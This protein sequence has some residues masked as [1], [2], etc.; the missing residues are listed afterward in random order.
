MLAG[1]VGR[2]EEALGS[3]A[4]EYISTGIGDNKIVEFDYASMGLS[5]EEAPAMGLVSKIQEMDEKR[6]DDEAVGEIDKKEEYDDEKV[7]GRV[8]KEKDGVGSEGGAPP[9]DARL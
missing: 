9:H 2:E 8:K 7:G 3:T 4:E 1:G 5:G 6:D